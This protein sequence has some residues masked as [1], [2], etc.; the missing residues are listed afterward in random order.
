LESS[1]DEARESNKDLSLGVIDL[2]RF[3]SVNDSMG[4]LFG[5]KL[6]EAVGKRLREIFPADGLIAS[7]GGDEFAFQIA[8]AR[9]DA[10]ALAKRICTSLSDT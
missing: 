2:D 6:L 7:L 9:D 1:I 3:K 8:L 5:D 10:A 4:H